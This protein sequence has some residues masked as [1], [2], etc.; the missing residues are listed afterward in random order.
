MNKPLSASDISEGVL[1]VSDSMSAKVTTA[2]SR[3]ATKTTKAISA[4]LKTGLFEEAKSAARELEFTSALED[5]EKTIRTFTQSAA[6]VGAGA[7]DK[8]ATSI[9]AQAGYP[10]EVNRSAVSLT[11][12]MIAAQLGRTTRKRLIAQIERSER[13]QKAASPIDPDKLANDINR[14]LR[15][16]IRRVVDVSANI[17]G[18][19]VASHGMLYEAR[20]R[21]ITRY[22]IDA[23]LDDRTTD[24]CRNM[25]GREFEVEQAFYRTQMALSIT[26]P[27]DQKDFMPFPDI[28]ELTGEKSRDLQAK[29]FDVPP[30]HFLCRSV[31]VLLGTDVDYDPVPI[32]KFPDTPPEYTPA[33]IDS[34][35]EEFETTTQAAIKVDNQADLLK[36]KDVA[37]ATPYHPGGDGTAARAFAINAYT[38][39]AFNSINPTLRHKSHWAD[40]ET[41]EIARTLDNAFDDVPALEDDLVVYRG[42]AGAVLDQLDDIG[43]VVQDDGF[44][45]TSVTPGAATG[46][47][48]QDAIL[49]ILVPAGE[50]VLPLGDLSLTKYEGEVILPRSIQFRVI[51]HGEVNYDGSKLRV[52]RVVMQGQTRTPDLDNLP[53]FEEWIEAQTSLV[54]DERYRAKFFYT[55]AKDLFAVSLTQG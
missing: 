14:Y 29:G 38:G 5:Q 28:N 48:R 21:G 3:H 53:D 10:F 43:K 55:A 17:V 8:P 23:V 37:D 19:R 50:K 24:I 18:T 32:S 6:L 2:L 15:G 34:L 4:F 9:M 46:F 47:G 35:F 12:A 54:K 52:I 45:S 22:R 13:F 39:N 49:Q 42:A 36:A 1:T 40:E 51:G 25:H 26:D 44:V 16:E 27:K 20:A 41:K 11:Q 31:V 30:F 7:V 33:K